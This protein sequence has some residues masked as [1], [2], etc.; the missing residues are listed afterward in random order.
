[1]RESVF[2][3]R[4]R[5]TRIM[6]YPSGARGCT[7]RWTAALQLGDLLVERRHLGLGLQL[8]FAEAGFKLFFLMLFGK[9][10]E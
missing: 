4:Q 9:E 8:E 2:V 5:E 1:M 7:H 6:S 10:A 3:G